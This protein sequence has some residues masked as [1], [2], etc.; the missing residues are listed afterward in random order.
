M[1]VIKCMLVANEF[2]SYRESIA[3]VMRL[4]FPGL[5]VFEAPSA[6]L[7]REVLRL[8]PDLVICS[9][10]TPLVTERVPNW[11]E[12]Y[13]ESDAPSKFSVDGESY[14]REQVDL[15]DLLAFVARPAAHTV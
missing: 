2:A 11:V 4:S 6:A 15:P 13:P 8:R 14:T 1:G 5:W 10:I 9:R 3:A 12:L 7:D